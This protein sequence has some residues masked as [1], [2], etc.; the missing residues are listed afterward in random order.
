MRRALGQFLDDLSKRG[1]SENRARRITQQIGQ[2]RKD[3]GERQSGKNGK[4]VRTPRQAMQGADGQRGMT[5]VVPRRLCGCVCGDLPV[6]MDMYVLFST[7]VVS[8]DV[9]AAR[10]R[11]P[12][13]PQPDPKQGHANQSLGEGRKAFQSESI[14]E[15]EQKNTHKRNTPTVPDAPS[16]PRSPGSTPFGRGQ[17]CHRRKV[18]GP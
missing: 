9:K 11:L 3:S 12:E 7:M 1:H 4:K 18:I 2:A 5:M 10:Q 8:M 13:S 6:K 14:T 15:Q 17:R 16:R